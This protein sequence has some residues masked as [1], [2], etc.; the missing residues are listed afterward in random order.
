MKKNILLI[1]LVLIGITC[2]VNATNDK[3][4]ISNRYISETLYK[5][6]Y[7]DTPEVIK[8]CILELKR[9][10][11][12]YPE[13]WLTPYYISL[14]NLRLVLNRSIKDYTNELEEAKQTIPLI[15]NIKNADLSEVYTLKGMYQYVYLSKYSSFLGKSTYKKMI[16]QFDKAIQLKPSNPRAKMLKFLAQ[17]LLGKNL[18]YAIDNEK[19]K[20]DEITALL[21]NEN[22]TSPYPSWGKEI[23]KVLMN[24]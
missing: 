18:G 4:E 9:I 8:N 20:I 10:A 7:S 13:N 21:N 12:Y 3:I 17:Y 23:W 2:N 19:M 15:M 16:E 24:R 5:A 6:G 22:A 1:M 11:K 14:Y